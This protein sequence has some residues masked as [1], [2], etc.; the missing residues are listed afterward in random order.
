MMA[1]GEWEGQEERY[2]NLLL[3][4]ED[5]N[6]K[7]WRCD[8]PP[9]SLKDSNANPKVKTTKEE[10]IEV[11]S[12]GRNTSRVRRVCWNFEIGTRMSDK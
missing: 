9:N 5:R 11:H 1:R 4:L 2:P 7:R 10:R 12:L 8:A 6:R 3:K